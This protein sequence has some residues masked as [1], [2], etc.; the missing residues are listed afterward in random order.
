MGSYM[1]L[2]VGGPFDL[3]R[4]FMQDKKHQVYFYSVPKYSPMSSN[5]EEAYTVSC[6]KEV[7]LRTHTCRDGTIVY[8]YKENK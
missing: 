5:I 8:E 7:Y 4:R 3:T 2:F 1:C 6:T